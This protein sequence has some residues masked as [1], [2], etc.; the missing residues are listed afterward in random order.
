MAALSLKIRK[1]L[2]ALL[3]PKCWA[4]LSRGV[5]PSSEHLSA[6]RK[7]SCD[8]II[9]VGANKGQFSLIARIFDPTVPIEAFE[10][11]PEEASIY[12]KIFRLDPYVKLHEVALGGKPGKSDLHISRRRDSSS[13]LPIGE[14]QAKLF[15]NTEE[16]GTHQVQVLTLDE[17]SSAWADSQRMLLKLDV[18]GF[19]LEVLRGAE[20][21]LRRCAY[22]YAECSEVAL[23]TGQ[24][25]FPEVKLFLGARGFRHVQSFN[26]QYSNGSLIQADHLF[27]R[28]R[29]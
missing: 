2:F 26:E 16:I 23:Y 6:L 29:S 15:E 27:E 10:P 24:A 12:R 7:M 1:A 14:L 18:Q 19:E 20:S 3:R 5:A 8:R 17:F 11:Q 9:D 21:F 28:L 13:L 22:V 25:L 4:A